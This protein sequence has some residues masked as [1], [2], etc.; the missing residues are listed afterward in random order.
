MTSSA[1][2]KLG[3][4]Q[5]VNWGVL[6]YTFSVFLV[7]VQHDLNAPQWL[8]AGAFSVALLASAALAPLA[9]RLV[10]RGNGPELL[11]RGGYASALLLALWATVPTL[12]TT[13]FVWAGIGACMAATLY[14]P[15]FAIVAR[16]IAD[17]ATRLRA[18]STI[19]VLGGL[20][21]TIFVPFAALLVSAWGWRLAVLSL[22]CIVAVATFF[23]SIAAVEAPATDTAPPTSR[24]ADIGP[25]VRP[26]AILFSA[27]SLANVVFTTTAVAAFIARGYT[28]TRAAFLGGLLGVMQ[29]PGRLLL[30]ASTTPRSP[31]QL[32]V[33]S[34]LL[35]SMGLLTLAADSTASVAALG[36]GA[37]ALGAGLMTLVRPYLV[38]SVFGAAASGDAGGLITRAQ[39]IARAAGPIAGA[40]FAAS[41]GYE[42]MFVLLAIVLAVLALATRVG[43]NA[44]SSPRFQ[45]AL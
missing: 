14:E 13:Y 10:D 19:T 18:L 26:M 40:A 39:Q 17:A 38:Q 34:L 5:C 37:F 8:I 12:A 4:G 16:A 23:C 21:S 44:L 29:L 22:A 2:L 31:A 25:A 43:V 15:A 42:T 45:E 9:G 3:I 20:A 7:P 41:F 6:Y 28:P 35:Q 36:V 33:A 1:M 30:M 27:A 32:L 11:R 24:F